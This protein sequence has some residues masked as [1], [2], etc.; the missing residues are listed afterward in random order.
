MVNS[1]SPELSRT[2][3]TLRRHFNDVILTLWTGPGFND[4]L[5]LPYEAVTSDASQPLPPQRYRAMACARQLY[6]YANAPGEVLQ[7]H[8]A[9][10]FDSLIHYFRDTQH[11]GW[12]YS[13]DAEARALDDTQDLYTHAFIVFACAAY[14][15]RCHRADV[16][17]VMLQTAE[18]IE[19]RFRTRE[20]AYHAALSADWA[21]VI[22]GPAQNPIMHLTEA[23]LGAARVAEPAWFAQALRN[24]AQNVADMFL[25][26]TALC[27]TEA[28]AGT[29][30]NPIEPG[31]QFEW[32]VL[33]S[34]APEVFAQMPLSLTLPR[35]CDWARA[36][37]VDAD[38]MGVSAAL[39]ETGAIRDATQRIWAQAEYARYL[40]A[41]GDWPALTHQLTQFQQRFLHANGWR[42]CLDP[43]GQVVRPDMPSTTPYHL[44]TCY[45]A[46][47]V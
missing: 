37:G 10:L 25:H 45:A 40:A 6:V 41:V 47:P 8:A 44:A 34:S 20:G 32:Y 24:I 22:A 1:V 3:A 16:R 35:G 26:P 17:Q 11:G 36:R 27:I 29:A 28:P 7:A 12:R 18:Q 42:E 14:F 33:L 15:E 19:T 39:D 5:E 31:H 13:I 4:R 46:L 43:Q 21:H 2:I 38:T 23:Y 30:N 9:K